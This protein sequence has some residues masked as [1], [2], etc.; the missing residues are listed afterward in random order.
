MIGM[1]TSKTFLSAAKSILYPI[2]NTARVVT[3]KKTAA[4]SLAAPKISQKISIGSFL[5]AKNVI[6][7][8]F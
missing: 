3:V 1:C 5:A 4:V 7:K 8:G 2:A 6:P